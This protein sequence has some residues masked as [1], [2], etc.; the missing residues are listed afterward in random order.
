[1]MIPTVARFFFGDII[2]PS[3]PSDAVSVASVLF[4][5]CGLV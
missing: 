2:R 3:L 4:A 5:C 1:M